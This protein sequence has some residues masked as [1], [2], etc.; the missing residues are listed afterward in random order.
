MAGRHTVI[1]GVRKM[2]IELQILL[3]SQLEYKKPN[4]YYENPIQQVPQCCS[5]GRRGI[6]LQYG[7]YIRRFQ[8]DEMQRW[9][10]R[11]IPVL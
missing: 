2:T 9:M 3:C 1:I 11:Y 6:V 10:K 4:I 5:G 7:I 8:K